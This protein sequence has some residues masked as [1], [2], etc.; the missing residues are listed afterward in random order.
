MGSSGIIRRGM[1][2]FING[3]AIRRVG[4]FGFVD[5]LDSMGVCCHGFVRPFLGCCR[6]RRVDESASSMTIFGHMRVFCGVRGIL[7]IRMALS[8]LNHNT[9][10]LDMLSF[11]RCTKILYANPQGGYDCHR[12]EDNRQHLFCGKTSK[13]AAGPRC[14]VICSHKSVILSNA[15]IFRITIQARH[16]I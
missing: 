6:L 7:T 8:I 15:Y 12:H 13:A 1:R 10:M 11:I 5:V 9:L 16:K 14:T 4:F 2:L 3:W